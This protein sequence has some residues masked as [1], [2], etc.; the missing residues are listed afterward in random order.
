[1][2]WWIWVLIGFALL[3]LEFVTTTMHVGLFA[4]GAFVASLLVAL[5]YGGPL[6]LQIVVF[7]AVSLLGLFVLRP[8]LLRRLRPAASRPVDSMVGEK[9]IAMDALAPGAM[10]K[11]ELRGSA[12]NARNVGTA[13]IAAGQRCTV[14][15]VEGL[16]LHVRSDSHN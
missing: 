9:A 14:E 3:A 1:M 5:G 2:A 4:L 11:A 16:L 8:I 13:E 15:M 10:G 12:W 7:T 6:W